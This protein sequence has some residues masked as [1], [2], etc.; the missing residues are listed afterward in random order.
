MDNLFSFI[1]SVLSDFLSWR[2]RKRQ[3]ETRRDR[4]E[5]T[6]GG[7]RRQEETDKT[8]QEKA[9]GGKRKLKKQEYSMRKKKNE[10]Y[11]YRKS[12]ILIL[13]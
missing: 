12:R 8:K 10:M 1:F 13:H 9:R 7:K 11:G 6:R 2:E 5:K 4:Q 3:E